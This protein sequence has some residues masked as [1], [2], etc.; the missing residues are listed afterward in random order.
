MYSKKRKDSQVSE[1]VVKCSP[2]E[3]RFIFLK[4]E[5]KS[6]PTKLR[7][8]GRYFFNTENEFRENIREQKDQV[9]VKMC[10]F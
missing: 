10:R 6:L 7:Q 3:A 8:R 1:D 9:S 2:E 5:K 4:H